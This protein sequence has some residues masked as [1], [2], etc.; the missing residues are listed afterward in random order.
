MLLLVLLS[1]R[2]AVADL[3]TFVQISLLGVDISLFRLAFA[4]IV[5]F[6]LHPH[7]S[8]GVGGSGH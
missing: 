2:G 6:L 7:R 1:V 4:A 5:Y 3:S 8:S